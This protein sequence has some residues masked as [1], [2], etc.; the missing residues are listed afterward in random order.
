[1]MKKPNRK[2]RKRKQNCGLKNDVPRSERRGLG[3]GLWK[4]ERRIEVVAEKGV[5]MD[6][7]MKESK[8][9]RGKEMV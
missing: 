6:T 7:E 3:G 1:M 4:R 2:G 9:I 5:A 8:V